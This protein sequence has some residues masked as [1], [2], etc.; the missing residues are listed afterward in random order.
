MTY[1]IK[2]RKPFLDPYGY[3]SEYMES[4]VEYIKD[5][6]ELCVLFLDRVIDDRRLAQKFLGITV[7]KEDELLHGIWPVE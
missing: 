5:N 4:D 1:T 3:T 2:S 7:S 6:I